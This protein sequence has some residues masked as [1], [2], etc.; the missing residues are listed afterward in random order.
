MK[1][2][3]NSDVNGP[4][5][6]SSQTRWS[7]NTLQSTHFSKDNQRTTKPNRH[8]KMDIY[9]NLWSKQNK[10][11]NHLCLPCVFEHYKKV[12]PTTAFYQ[13]WGILEE[14]GKKQI[15]IRAKMIDDLIIYIMKLQADNHEV[16]LNI[17]TNK[18]FDLEKGGLAKLISMNKLVDPIACTHGSKHIPNTDQRGT[19]R[20][21][22]IFVSQKL[23]KYIQ[24]CGITPFN[25]VS[26]SDHRGSF[27]DLHLIAYL[28]NTFQNIIDASSRLFQSND[29]KRVTKYKQYLQVF[30]K[31]HNIIAQTDK[32]REGMKNKILTI[33]DIPYIDEL[34]SLI[35]TGTLAVEVSITRIENRESWSPILANAIREVSLWKLIKSDKLGKISKNDKIKE[36]INTM[37][38]PVNIERNC[39]KTICKNLQVAQTQLK[40]VKQNCRHS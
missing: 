33:T 11:R 34:D 1:Q 29:I 25:Q 37:K 4:L 14:K 36:I 10:S 35:T 23:Y 6:K 31:R 7:C 28:Q 40:K 9:Y 38:R 20:I 32:I 18:S 17:D 30:V 21:Y 39:L 2:I 5:E 26:P 3:D 15:A 8:R 27:I 13:Q 24:A 16:A 12:G 22:F 19:K